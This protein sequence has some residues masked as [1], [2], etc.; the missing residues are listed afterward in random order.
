MTRSTNS[1]P[2]PL[3]RRVAQMKR[4]RYVRNAWFGIRYVL[5]SHSITY[6][7]LRYAPAPYARVIVEKD[8]DACIEGL[9]RSANTFGGWAFLEQNPDVRLAHHMHVPMQ[10]LRAVRLGVPCVVLIRRP[11][12]NLTSLVIAGENDLS[13]DLAF[14][15]YIDYYRRMVPIRERIAICTFVE[16]L[17]D[18]SVI[19]R[20][21]NT[22]Y[23]TAFAAAPMS[24]ATKRDIVARLERNERNMR[25]RPGHGTVPNRYKDELK[26]RVLEALSRHPLLPR[27]EA[28]YATL[29]EAAQ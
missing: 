4:P 17:E 5:G 15:I 29:A 18:P 9:P 20:R 1:G 14:R 2:P 27:A 10:T 25:S 3:S 6:P 8:M 24:E 12:G 28:A 26:P 19:A 23:G 11:L 21:L 7:I 16:V 13:H 22:A